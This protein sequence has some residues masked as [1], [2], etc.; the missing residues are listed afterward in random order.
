MIL[1]EAKSKR[2]SSFLF[3]K[4]NFH[5]ENALSDR[6]LDGFNNRKKAAIRSFFPSGT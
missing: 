1:D 3:E 2:K 4:V 5:I 6:H